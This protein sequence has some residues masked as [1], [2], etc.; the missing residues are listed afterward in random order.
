MNKLELPRIKRVSYG[1]QNAVSSGCY[2]VPY[3]AKKLRTIELSMGKVTKMT[4]VEYADNLWRK[5]AS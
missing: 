1:I 4:P 2:R 3:E 5:L